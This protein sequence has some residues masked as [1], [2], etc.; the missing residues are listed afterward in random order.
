MG[1]AVSSEFL[2]TTFTESDQQYSK[3]AMNA[4][5]D[6]A[7]VWE[8]YQDRPANTT[9]TD[10]ANS[11]GVYGQRFVR[12]SLIGTSP[13]IGP[14]GEYLDEFRANTT[15][16]G[17]QRYPSIAMDDNGDFLVVWS[18]NGTRPGQ[19]DSQGVFMQRFDLPS[20]K[21]GARV[22][23]T[24]DA[25]AQI[26]TVDE[27]QNIKTNVTTF[28][29][30]IS[31]DLTGNPYDAGL[32]SV[33]RRPDRRSQRDESEQ[34]EPREERRRDLGRRDALGLLFRRDHAHVT[35]SC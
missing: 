16:D 7:I 4:A 24:Y 9:A 31:E 5:G 11:F 19:T 26:Q 15:T 21:A 30:T 20:D 17:D 8:S 18:G 32:R 22:I 6:F 29:V 33:G 23:Q 2:V 14:N 12:T 13:N 27:G 3:V 25:T 34:L 35:R 10:A 1:R 28:I